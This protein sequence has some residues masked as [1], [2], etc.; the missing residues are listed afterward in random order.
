M[1]N[2]TA[3]VPTPGNHRHNSGPL[4]RQPWDKAARLLPHFASVPQVMDFPRHLAP[5][6]QRWTPSS[7]LL[8]RPLRG[9]CGGPTRKPMVAGHRWR[10]LGPHEA[11]LLPNYSQGVQRNPTDT[12]RPAMGKPISESKSVFSHILS[13]NLEPWTLT[14]TI[15]PKTN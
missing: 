7:N 12:C 8:R 6:I 9:A 3:A 14:S 15:L 1:C 4:G 2:A 11:R 10:G 5:T 13:L